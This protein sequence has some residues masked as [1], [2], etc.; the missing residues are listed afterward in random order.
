MADKVELEA[1]EVLGF[2]GINDVK[3]LDDLKAKFN[4]KYI[5]SETHNKTLGELN[6][7]FTHAIKKGFKEI[8][9]E[10][11]SDELKD[12]DTVAVPTLVAEKVKTRFEELES[13][14]KL[15]KEQMESKLNDDLGKYKKQ[16]TEK[17]DLLN[18]LKTE[19]TDFK[20]N[21]ENEKKSFVVN[22]KKQDATKGLTFSDQSSEFEKKGFYYDIDSNY[23]FAVEDGVEMVRSKDGNPIKSEAKAGEYA[24]FSEF[25]NTKFKE[26]GLGAVSNPKK[27]TTFDI[28]SGGS[29]EPT[30]A[31]RKVAARH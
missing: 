9:V 20:T 28:G 6:G 4:E 3:D 19:Y 26:S 27:V 1:K 21:V 8:G 18:T 2:I 17:E 22:S 11:T 16:L 10:L 25:Y 5:P 14:S 29:K 31:K 30:V 7:K 15:T 12:L 13:Q 24:S 23:S